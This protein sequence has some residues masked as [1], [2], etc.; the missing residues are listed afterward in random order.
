MCDYLIV[1]AV[2]RVQL[3]GPVDELLASHRRLIGPPRDPGTLPATQEV[4]ESSHT[5]RQSTF[6]IHTDEPIHDPSWTV[7]TVS[8]EDLVLAYMGRGVIAEPRR[9]PI[10]EVH[11]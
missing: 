5:D 10:L 4:I 9:R 8:L 2:S 6:F 1:L 7:E 11:R 3:A